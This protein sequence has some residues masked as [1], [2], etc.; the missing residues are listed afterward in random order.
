MSDAP[1]KQRVQTEMI[2]A[3]K[4]GQKDRTQVIR[5]VLSEIK[6]QEADKPDADPQVAVAAYAKKLQKTAADMERLNQ[7]DRVAALK[8]ELAIVQEF[9]PREISDAD[10]EALV[11]TTLA[12]LGPRTPKDQGKAIGLVMK[13]IATTQQSA[14]PN[15]VRTLI[16]TTISS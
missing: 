1:L 5:M 14:D 13:A 2:A 4:A 11:A 7:P 10:L 12:P 15:K 6:A 8:A 3:M 9:L 16:Q